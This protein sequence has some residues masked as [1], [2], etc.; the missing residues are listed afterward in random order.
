MLTE[1]GRISVSDTR[2]IV[3]ADDARTERPVTSQHDYQELL[4]EHF[5]IV[6]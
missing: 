5:G 2:F 4:R 1:N 6:M 3:S